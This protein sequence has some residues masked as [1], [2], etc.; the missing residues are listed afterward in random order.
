[1]RRRSGGRGGYCEC[2]WDDALGLRVA[3][4][5]FDGVDGLTQRHQSAKDVVEQATTSGETVHAEGYTKICA[6]GN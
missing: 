2:G 6:R 3:E 4:S 1:M 5:N